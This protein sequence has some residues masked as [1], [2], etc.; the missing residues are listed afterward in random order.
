MKLRLPRT[1]YAL[2]LALFACG[3]SPEEQPLAPEPGEELSGG[4]TTVFET[5]HDAYTWPCTNL[6]SAHRP[7]FFSGN[8][9]FN[10]NWV[11]APASTDGLDGLGPTFNAASC[12]S[13]HFKDG[14]GSPPLSAG[15]PFIGLLLRLSIPGVDAHGGPLDEPSYGGQFNHHAILDVQAEG[16]S[17]V[18]YREI[19]GKFADGTPYALQEPSYS[20]AALAFGPMADGVLISPRTAPSVF[21]LGLLEAVPEADILARADEDDGDGDGISGRPNYVWDVKRKVKALGRFGWK[22]NQPGLE[23]QN[24]GAFVGDLGISSPLFPTQNCPGPQAACTG[25]LHGGEP[26]IDQKKIDDVTL[27]TRV[28]GVPARRRFDRPDVLAGKA[29]FADLGCASCHTPRMRT[30]AATELSELSDQ[31]FFPYTDLLLHD[32]GEELA[33]GR[34]DFEATGSEWRTPPLWGLGLMETVNHHTRL[35][36]D[37]RARDVSEAILWHGGEAEAAREAY[38]SLSSDER[39]LLLTFLDSL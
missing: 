7:A 9:L 14:R 1:G 4:A 13:C 20:F 36:H 22:A 5:A 17:Q 11:P 38:R 19:P 27:Y 2:L 29:L 23:Q 39:A 12:S 26:E 15:Q 24:S 31:T 34:P 18:S 30:A 32:M 35:L 21:G 6:E 33:D 37:G 28:L 16:E 8:A 25:A 10:R 3:S